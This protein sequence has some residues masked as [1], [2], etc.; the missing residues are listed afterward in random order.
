MQ[1]SGSLPRS[2]SVG[3]VLSLGCGDW[4]ERKDSGSL[5]GERRGRKGNQ[6]T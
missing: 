4:S 3:V 1:F 5:V 6:A 2:V